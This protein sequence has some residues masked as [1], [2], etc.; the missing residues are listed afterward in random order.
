MGPAEIV[1]SLSE[2]CEEKGPRLSTEQIVAWIE[3]LNGFESEMELIAFAKKM[4]ARQYARMLEYDDE[5]VGRRIKRLWSFRDRRRGRRFYSDILQ[6]PEHR[7]RRLR[8][9]YIK[10]AGQLKSVRRAMTDALNGQAFFEFYADDD[11]EESEEPA[12]TEA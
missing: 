9:E 5:E 11:L 7:R 4:K 10:F 8:D 3:N 6:M 1:A 2:L 12:A